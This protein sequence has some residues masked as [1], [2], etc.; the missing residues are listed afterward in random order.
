MSKSEKATYV[1]PVL[2][3]VGSFEEITLGNSTGSALD[4][5]FPVGTPFSD[6]TFS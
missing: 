5:S 4:A 2:N 6:L 1:K 3:R